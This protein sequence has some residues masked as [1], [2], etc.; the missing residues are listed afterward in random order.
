MFIGRGTISACS[1]SNE[2]IGTAHAQ[3]ADGTELIMEI[4]KKQI[5]VYGETADYVHTGFGFENNMRYYTIE[6][7]E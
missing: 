2:L 3:V 5:A 6:V 1:G 4:D 7:N